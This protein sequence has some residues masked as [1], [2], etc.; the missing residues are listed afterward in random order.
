M[1]FGRALGYVAVGWFGLLLVASLQAMLPS[2][3]AVCPD[4]VLLVVFYVGLSP[5]GGVASVCALGVALGYLA[6]LSSGG[7]R[8]LHMLVY[9]LVGLGVR[10]LSTRVLVRGLGPTVLVAAVGATLAGVAVVGLRSA[11]LGS[12][13]AVR[14]LSPL[15]ASVLATTLL[16]PVV[17]ALLARL[18][19]RS[20]RT[21]PPRSTRNLGGAHRRVRRATLR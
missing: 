8:G 19:A 3:W 12:V 17:F 7:P 13:F 9:A 20:S 15:P 6:D 1:G 16:A 18:D 11:L 21:R 14:A 4:V 10:T 5:R 2:A